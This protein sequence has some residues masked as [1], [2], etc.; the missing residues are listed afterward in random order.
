[1]FLCSLTVQNWGATIRLAEMTWPEVKAVLLRK[2]VVILPVGSTEEH[3]THLPLNVDS[4]EAA[5]VC[6]L[7]AGMAEKK[8][9]DI[10]VLVAPT[11]HYSDVSVHKMFPG[12]IGIKIDTFISTV[13]DIVNNFL[14]QGFQNVIVFVAHVEDNCS[15]ETAL[16][17][18]V[19]NAPGARVFAA[20]MVEL[21]REVRARICKAGL[22]GVGHAL[23][24]ETS[25][26]LYIQPQNVKLDKAEI[27]QRQL[28]FT[29]KF[30][31]ATGMSKNLGLSYYNQLLNKGWEKSGVDG[32]PTMAS[33]EEGEAIINAMAADL[34]EIIEQ[35][36][37]LGIQ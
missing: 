28:P 7:A 16:R 19:D 11:I 21:G 8:Y 29:E 6:E 30:V 15:V 24:S 10:S 37:E 13:E 25:Q 4:A 23:E 2:N 32:D 26:C 17:K 5:F 9:Q 33:R 3:G 27:G 36:L 12:T 31:G 35:A 20:N 22:K 14:S 18:V 34:A 1:M